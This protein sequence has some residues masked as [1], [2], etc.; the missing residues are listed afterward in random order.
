M[1]R[2]NLGLITCYFRVIFQDLIKDLKSELG[3][4]FEDVIL[5]LME[6]PDEY[7]AKECHRAIEVRERAECRSAGRAYT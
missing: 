5:A 6:K 3:G 7:D 2:A 1:S 4:R